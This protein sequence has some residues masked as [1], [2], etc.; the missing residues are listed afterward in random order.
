MSAVLGCRPVSSR[1]I[2][3]C[4]RAAPFHITILQVNAPTSGHEDS[5]VDNFYQ[6]LQGTIHQ[7]P[8]KKE[9]EC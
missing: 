3:I 9:L 5:K 2:S 4:L 1:F 6:L 7:T 8:K